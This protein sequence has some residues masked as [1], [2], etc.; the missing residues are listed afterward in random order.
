MEQNQKYNMKQ[1]GYQVVASTMLML[2]II[3][4]LSILMHQPFGMKEQMK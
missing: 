2:F 3:W 1:Y 4:E